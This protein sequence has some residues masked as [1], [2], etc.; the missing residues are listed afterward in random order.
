MAQ[1]PVLLA[2][3]LSAV[4]LYPCSCAQEH[5]GRRRAGPAGCGAAGPGAVPGAAPGRAARGCS[6]S[7]ARSLPP[8][9]G[10]V[11]VCAAEKHY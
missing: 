9:R 6:G 5:P 3:Y 11:H 7:A 4:F 1:R 8:G 10:R 2:D